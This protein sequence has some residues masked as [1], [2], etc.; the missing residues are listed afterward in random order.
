MKREELLMSLGCFHF[1]RSVLQLLNMLLVIF[2]YQIIKRLKST[3]ESWG[4]CTY[5]DRY[6]ANEDLVTLLNSD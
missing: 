4:I 5:E 6:R 3:T 1:V 2:I